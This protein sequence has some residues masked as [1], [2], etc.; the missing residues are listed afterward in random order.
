MGTEFALAVITATVVFILTLVFGSQAQMWFITVGTALVLMPIL[1]VFLFGTSAMLNADAQAAKVTADS[2][3]EMIV[4]YVSQ[5]LPSIVISEVAGA[6][7][8]TVGGT[9]VGM[10]KGL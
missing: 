6:I 4:L 3:V 9:M 2:T 8:G 10:A 7:V 1:I 5:K